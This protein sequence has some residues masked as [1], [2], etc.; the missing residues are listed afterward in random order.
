MHLPLTGAVKVPSKLELTLPGFTSL[1]TIYIGACHFF[2]LS[3][4]FHG[5]QH[6]LIIQTSWQKRWIRVARV[7]EHRA[8]VVQTSSSDNAF[9]FRIW[10]R[11]VKS[12]C[13][14]IGQEKYRLNIFVV[15]IAVKIRE[16]LDGKVNPLLNH[17]YMF[18]LQDLVVRYLHDLIRQLLRVYADVQG[19]FNFSGIDSKLESK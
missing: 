13:I 14:Y 7:I 2:T 10:S 19:S 1:L 6:F 15:H 9:W 17:I 3:Y 16:V 4:I 12:P 18:V 5:N 11:N 8:N